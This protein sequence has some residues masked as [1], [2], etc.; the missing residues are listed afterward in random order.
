MTYILPAGGK[1]GSPLQAASD[2]GN[3]E[4][5]KLLLDNGA[6]PNTLGTSL[7]SQRFTTDMVPAG[8]VCGTALQAASVL[9]NLELV[10]L[11]LNK[12]A[13]P[14]ALGKGL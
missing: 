9:G 4:V 1:Y 12:G 3:L 7:R 2:R 10:E 14:N 5:V 13:D 11:L 8:G 6:D